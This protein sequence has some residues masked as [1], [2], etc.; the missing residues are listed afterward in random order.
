MGEEFGADSPFLFFCDFGGDLADAVREGRRAEFAGFPPFD[1]PAAAASIPDPGAEQT[2]ARSRLDWSSVARAPHADW[3]SLYRTLL[4]RR[5]ASIVPLVP[6]VVPGAA[7]YDV[8]AGGTL[9][10]RWALDDGRTLALVTQPRPG[11]LPPPVAGATPIWE[12]PPAQGWST[13]WSV[14]PAPR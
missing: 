12:P 7:R 6:H 10:V 1:D 4:A 3:L 13:R 5:A 14:E 11:T 8:G 2:L 9:S